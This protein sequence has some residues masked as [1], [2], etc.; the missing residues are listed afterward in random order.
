MNQQYWEKFY[1]TFKVTKYSSFAEFCVKYLK[2]SEKIIDL[3]CGNG[4]DSYFFAKHGFEVVGI[5]IA[6][7]PEYKKNAIF[8]QN[9]FMHYDSFL[10]PVY[11][12]FFLHSISDN[13]IIQLFQKS[14][15]MLL[16]EFRDK[17]DHP[18]IYKHLRN[19]VDGNQI[20]KSLVENNFDILFYQKSKGLAVFKEEDPLICRVIAKRK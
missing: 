6:S 14:R 2:K 11:A 3:G 5:D 16:L 4:R 19:H 7:R 13:D 18:V 12:R 8:F 1:K 20:I 9:D 10:H 17:S 15:D